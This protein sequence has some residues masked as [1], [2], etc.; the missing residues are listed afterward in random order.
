[1]EEYLVVEKDEDIEEFFDEPEE[2][3]EGEKEKRKPKLKEAKKAYRAG[4]RAQ[5]VSG[6]FEGLKGFLG[7]SEGR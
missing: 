6:G 1:M 2:I 3:T 4:Q 7:G 5:K